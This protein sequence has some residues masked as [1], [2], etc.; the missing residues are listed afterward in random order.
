[1]KKK[2]LLMGRS[3]CGKTS[4]RALVFSST[5]YPNAASTKRLGTT[6]GVETSHFRILRN[7]VISLF[8][9]GGQQAYVDSYLDDR[10]SQVFKDVGAFV[11]VFDMGNSSDQGDDHDDGWEADFR[12]WKDCIRLLSQHS[13]QAHVF[14]LLHKMDLVESSRRKDIYAQRVKELRLKAKELMMPEPPK[15]C[16]TSIWDETLYRAWSKIVHSLVPNIATLEDNLTQF[17]RLTAATDAVI[18]ERK[19]FLVIARSEAADTTEPAPGTP[20]APQE[21]PRGLARNAHKRSSPGEDMDDLLEG[22]PQTDAERKSILDKGQMHPERFEKISELVKN[23]RGSCASKL[24]SNFQSLE[25]R[26]AAFSAYL[27]VFTSDTYML[28][29]VAGPS[30][31][32]SKIKHNVTLIR[33]QFDRGA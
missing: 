7:L 1:M 13:P 6:L 12:Y 2:I 18:F 33:D 10:K 15:C 17:A 27:D 4:M 9:M 24:Q 3:G 30:V 19:T 14:C 16:G 32:L 29:I 25:L 31:D 11:Y 21:V 8:D 28:V 5:L 20:L 23:L 22:Y 26:D